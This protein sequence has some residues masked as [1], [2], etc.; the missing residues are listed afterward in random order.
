M[1]M[2]LVEQSDCPLPMILTP[3]L[4]AVVA[5]PIL[6]KCPEKLAGHRPSLVISG[7]SHDVTTLDWTLGTSTKQRTQGEI[8]THFPCTEV[9]PQTLHWARRKLRYDGRYLSWKL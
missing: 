1:Y 9:F 4:A 6:I 2:Y 5:A 3:T 7:I 8:T